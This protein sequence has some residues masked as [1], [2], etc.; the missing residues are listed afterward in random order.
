MKRLFF[1]VVCVLSGLIEAVA[2]GGSVSV[3][4]ET[5]RIQYYEAY[6]PVEETARK[7]KIS[8]YNSFEN[9]TGIAKEL[10]KM[11]ED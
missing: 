1:L 7:L 2:Q 6:P 5:F 8:N 9:P 3:W 4:K 11:M 10:S